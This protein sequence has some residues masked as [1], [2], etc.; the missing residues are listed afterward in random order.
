MLLAGKLAVAI[1][2]RPLFAG[3]PVVPPWIDIV[4]TGLGLLGLGI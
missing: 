4:A 2:A 3:L 1:P